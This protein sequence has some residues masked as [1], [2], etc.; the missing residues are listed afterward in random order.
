MSIS[1]ALWQTGKD[2]WATP[3]DLIADIEKELGYRFVLDAAAEAWNSR[4]DDRHISPSADALAVDWADYLPPD[5][6]TGDVWL[7]PPYSRNMHQ[8]LRKAASSA[9]EAKRRVLVLVFA[10]TDTRWWHDTVMPNARRIW[11]IRGRIRF[12]DAYGR[13]VKSGSPAPS[14]LVEFDGRD[15]ASQR[16]PLSVLSYVQP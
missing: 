1:R 3:P 2:D 13:Q 4:C 6:P 15:Y 12:L 9:V 14:C 8:W 10:R 16:L 7:N 5:D 11:L